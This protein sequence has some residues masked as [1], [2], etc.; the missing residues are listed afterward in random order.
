MVRSASALLEGPLEAIRLGIYPCLFLCGCSA[1][2]LESF[3]DGYIV[4]V[5]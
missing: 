4:C 1:L 3:L 2:F 5:V